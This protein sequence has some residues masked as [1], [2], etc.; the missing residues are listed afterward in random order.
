MGRSAPLI[1]ATTTM[2]SRKFCIYGN[3]L[4]SNEST[5]C[6]DETMMLMK[7]CESKLERSESNQYC[8]G[9]R[10]DG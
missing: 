3:E 1:P 2:N 4:V 7:R 10:T 6:S 8:S 5:A 9:W